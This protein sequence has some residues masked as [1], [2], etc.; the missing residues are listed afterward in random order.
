MVH[1]RPV[2]F[3]R[4]LEAV[5]LQP[6]WDLYQGLRPYNCTCEH[7]QFVGEHRP[8]GDA[9]H[10]PLCAIG[11]WQ[12]LGDKL[13][14]LGLD[15]LDSRST[16]RAVAAMRKGTKKPAPKAPSKKR[17]AAKRPAQKPA[18][19]GRTSPKRTSKRRR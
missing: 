1:A 3:Q 5:S 16:H 10:Y 18:P 8:D 7:Y 9:T 15:R 19:R 14:A 13:R 4:L 17:V 12:I 2:E 11:K 6:T